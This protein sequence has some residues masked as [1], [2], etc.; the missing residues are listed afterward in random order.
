MVDAV[1]P[2]ARRATLQPAQLRRE[3]RMIEQLDLPAIEG[4][5]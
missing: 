4:G 3:P 2:T 1:A 5:Q